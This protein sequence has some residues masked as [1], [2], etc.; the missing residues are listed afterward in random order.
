[1]MEDNPCLEMHFQG[2][3]NWML[4][5]LRKFIMFYYCALSA[6]PRS[7]LNGSFEKWNTSCKW[8]SWRRWTFFRINLNLNVTSRWPYPACGPWDTWTL[9]PWDLQTLEFWKFWSMNPPHSSFPLPPPT[10]LLLPPPSY[11]LL[12]LSS[13]SAPPISSPSPPTVLPH[14]T[15]N[16]YLS[17]SK[18]KS[19]E[20]IFTIFGLIK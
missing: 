17:N 1:M 5:L 14:L 8:V 19:N 9:G 11:I 18:I 2:K 15:N 12:P 13:P 3:K 16:N 20:Q 4:W 6:N 7:F 10:Y